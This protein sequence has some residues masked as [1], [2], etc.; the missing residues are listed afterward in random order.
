MRLRLWGGDMG[1]CAMPEEK[2]GRRA[3]YNEM[4]MKWNGIVTTN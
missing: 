2:G 1:S 4:N 3:I